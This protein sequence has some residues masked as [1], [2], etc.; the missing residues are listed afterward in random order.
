MRGL[1]VAVRP[2]EG[3]PAVSPALG[4][5]GGDALR[6]SVGPW[7]ALRTTLEALETALDAGRGRA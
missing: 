5:S 3:L 4:A 1:G 7:P 6:I 2:F